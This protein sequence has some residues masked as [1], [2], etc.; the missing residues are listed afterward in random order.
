VRLCFV[1]WSLT[2]VRSRFLVLLLP[3]LL[4]VFPFGDGNGIRVKANKY[5]STASRCLRRSRLNNDD[6][7]RAISFRLAK[8]IPFVGT[9]E[10]VY[11]RSRTRISEA[12]GNGISQDSS[13]LQDCARSIVWIWILSKTKALKRILRGLKQKMR[14]RLV[15]KEQGTALKVVGKFWRGRRSGPSLRANSWKGESWSRR[16]I[17]PTFRSARR[18][19]PF[20]RGIDHDSRNS[21]ITRVCLRASLGRRDD[22]VSIFLSKR[23]RWRLR[24]TR[25]STAL[26]SNALQE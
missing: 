7:R 9:F 8:R 12:S 17:F 14:F 18:L 13:R 23:A 26:A 2:R 22:K 25:E 20:V 11:S 24:E 4:R 10:F 15:P 5:C 1:E 16:S 6:K 21:L 3:A 19:V